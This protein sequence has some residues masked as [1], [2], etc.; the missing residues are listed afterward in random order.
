MNRK[1]FY[2][3]ITNIIIVYLLLFNGVSNAVAKKAAETDISRPH[4]Y[5]NFI[6]GTRSDHMLHS[7]AIKL[8]ALQKSRLRKIQ[9]VPKVTADSDVGDLA[10]IEDD[11]SL[12]LP[13]SPANPFDLD[14]KTLLFTPNGSGGYDVTQKAFTFDTNLGTRPPNVGDDT[15]HEF[16]LTNG[17]SFPYFDTT[18]TNIWVRSNGNVTFG[19]IGNPDFFDPDDFDLE[20]PMIAAFFTD[21]D[22]LVNGGVFVKFSTSKFVVTWNKITEFDQTNSNT[23]QLTLRSSGTFEISYNGIDIKEPAGVSGTLIVGYNSGNSDPT[24]IDVDFSAELPAGIKGSSFDIISELFRPRNILPQVDYME[25]VKRFYQTHGDDFDQIVMFTNFASDL[26]G[27][28]AFHLGVSNAV[29]GI[30]RETIDNTAN[31]G[32]TRRLKSFLN[33]NDINIW[34]TDPA[35]QFFTDGNSFLSIMAQESGHK[36]LAFVEFMTDT[37]ASNLMLGRGDAH[38]NRFA[39]TES[40]S[41]EG[42][43]WVEKSPNNFENASVV[44]GFSNLDLY[45]MGYRSPEEVPDFFYISSESNNTIANRSSQSTVNPGVTATGIRTN[46]TV[47]DIIAVEG[48]RTPTRDFSIKDHRQ[49]FILLVEK[50]STASAAEISKLQNFID[51]WRDYWNVHTDGRGTM[52]TSLTTNLPVAVLEGTVKDVSTNLPIENMQAELVEKGIKQP[53]ISGGYYTWR[54]LA[55]DLN[56][57]NESFTQVISAYPYF[58]DTST[59]TMAF[60]SSSTKNI[61]LTML[62]TGSISGT[63]ID[64]ISELPVET[65]VFLSV[66][67]DQIEDFVL[68]TASDSLGFYR[69]DSLFIS[70]PG[71]ITYKS[72]T[73]EPGLSDVAVNITDITVNEGNNV[74]NI[75][76]NAADLMLVNDDPTGNYID[77]YLDAL[78]SLRITYSQWKSMDKGP[79]S[80]I[81]IDRFGFPVIIWFTGDA[82]LDAISPAEEDSLIQFLDGG[83]RLFIT[84]QN[85]VES[86]PPASTLLTDYFEVSHGGNN[87]SDIVMR[88]IS[89]DPVTDGFSLFGIFGGNAAHNQTSPDIFMPT[90]NASAAIK[91]GTTGEN[92]SAV[93]IDNGTYKIFLAGFGMEALVEL[94]PTLTKRHELL[95]GVLDW[96]EVRSSIDVKED[97]SVALPKQFVLEQN[98]PNPFNPETSIDYSLF[99][100]AKVKITIFNILGQRVK[101]L[102]DR[103]LSA[104]KYTVIWNGSA[105]SG[106]LVASGVYF[107]RLEA[108]SSSQAGNKVFVDTKKMLFLK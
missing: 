13:P 75:T 69:F 99:Q 6:C 29:Q 38:W 90:G 36:W 7:K 82:G 19:N 93:S 61:N 5:D 77:F 94:D 17:F 59:I 74:I 96:F 63:I 53:V 16:N 51:A 105:E 104:G 83:G 108:I 35:A 52:S 43:D 86:L 40:S 102:V 68:E 14:K 2:I 78:D 26:G 54:A 79:A 3:S 103:D 57:P 100:S 55:D 106:R 4:I 73:L 60:G 39:F 23:I 24:S 101:T 37:G 80:T 11:G 18:W 45:L 10:I 71:V 58:P 34:I 48:L 41:L 85:V 95:S 70:L 84:G 33:M 76:L 12:T 20:L 30:N 89:G 21:L 31:W 65:T 42:N 9:F 62:P 15:N 91:Y 1:L 8:N 64:A 32:S 81:N 66:G 107:Y 97:L 50:D 92:V 56:P 47:D 27:G 87:A 25:T 67:S 72:I 28:F 98:Y 49:A 88:G 44:N 22:P 46:V